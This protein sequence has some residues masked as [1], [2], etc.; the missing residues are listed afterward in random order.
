[1][2]TVYQTQEFRDWLDAIKDVRAQVRI[3]ARLRLAETG[4]LGDWKPVG[5]EVSEMRVAFSSSCSRA[6]TSRRSREISSERNESCSN[7]SW[8]HEYIQGTN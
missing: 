2:F 7:W 8:N 5:N 3:A 1:M 4:D 6:A